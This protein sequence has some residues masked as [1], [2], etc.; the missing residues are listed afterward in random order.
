M[1]VQLFFLSVHAEYTA[2]YKR[3]V[4]EIGMREETRGE[5][6][7]HNTTQTHPLRLGAIKIPS[8]R[9]RLTEVP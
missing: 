3:G 7:I 2:V 6:V 8:P 1:G 4:G 5:T 9:V